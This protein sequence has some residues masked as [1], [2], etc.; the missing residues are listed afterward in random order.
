MNTANKTCIA[1]SAAVGIALALIV[2]CSRQTHIEARGD[3][4]QT[5]TV[6]VARATL[7]DLSHDLVL[8]AE[9]RPFQEIDVHAIVA[10][11]VKKRSATGSM[12]V[13]YWPSWRF[14]KW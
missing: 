5:I 7:A 2:S 11:Y 12:K 4:A 1:G 13:S 8:T 10:G 9:F 6:A 14:Q 3:P